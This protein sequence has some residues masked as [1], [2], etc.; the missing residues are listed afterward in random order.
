M[1][2]EEKG[3]VMG[4]LGSRKRRGSKFEVKRDKVI[5]FITKAKEQEEESE[6]EKVEDLDEGSRTIDHKALQD[7]DF[8]YVFDMQKSR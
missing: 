5:P 8:S 3:A 1:I 7:Y 6:E 4:G 2:E